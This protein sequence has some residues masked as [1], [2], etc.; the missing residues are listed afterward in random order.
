MS[1]YEPALR[2]RKGRSHLIANLLA[3][4]IITVWA[5]V[6]VLWDELPGPS[7]SHPSV[8]VPPRTRVCQDPTE[9]SDPTC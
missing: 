9:V 1:S 7:E 4:V 6:F 8:V 3:A 2:L 5:L